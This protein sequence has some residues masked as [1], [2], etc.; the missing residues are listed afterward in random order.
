[1]RNPLLKSMFRPRYGYRPVDF[2][3]ATTA[4]PVSRLVSRST[5]SGFERITLTGGLAGTS[6]EAGYTMFVP[7][8]SPSGVRLKFGQPWNARFRLRHNTATAPSTTSG[9]FIAAGIVDSSTTLVAR[10]FLSAGYC[11]IASSITMR[12]ESGAGTINQSGSSLNTVAADLLF[13]IIPG[14]SGANTGQGW[15]CTPCALDINGTRVTANTTI[16]MSA[17]EAFTTGGDAYAFV[18]VGRYDATAGNASIDV[19][20]DILTSEPALSWLE[21]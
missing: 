5:V 4:D 2:S 19:A 17:N 13:G 6:C 14:A 18:T 21:I 7:L 12:A 11:F 9:L 20:L 16:S 3:A 1:M 10:P 8:L 15:A